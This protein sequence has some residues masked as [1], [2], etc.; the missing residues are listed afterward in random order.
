GAGVRAR[1]VDVDYASHTAQVEAVEGELARSLAQIR[2]VSSR[3]PFFSTVEAGWLDTA[4]LDA[5]YWYRNLRSTV[6][7]A[8]SIDRLIEEGFAAF[9]EVSAHPVLTM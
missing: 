6:R 5:G 3:I 2:P 7:F 4:E 1:W 8:P 9:V